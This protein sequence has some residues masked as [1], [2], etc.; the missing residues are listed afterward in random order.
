MK[1]EKKKT[2]YYAGL[3]AAACLMYALSA[4]LR[5]V[6]GIMLGTIAK[7]TGI[8]YATVSFVIAVGQLVF[9]IMQPLFGIVALKRSNAFV[10]VAGFLM[11]GVGLAAIPFC[12]SKWMLMLFLGVVLPAGTGAVSFGIILGAIIPKLGERRGAVAS[13]FINASSGLGSIILSPTL[14]QLFASVGFT[15]TMSFMGALCVIL[16]PIAIWASV[17]N[18]RDTQTAPSNPIAGGVGVLLKNAVCGRNYQYLMIGF[19]TCGFHMAIIETH[20]YSQIVSYQIEEAWAAI[21][22]SVYGVAVMAGALGSGFLC[23]KFKMKNVLGGLY[24][25][26]TF[27][28]LAFLLLPKTLPIVLGI[29]VLLGL[30]SAATVVPTAGLVSK[31]FGSQTLGTLFGFV[32]LCHQ[33]GSFFSAWLGGVCLS[34][35][36]NYV[37]IWCASAVLCLLAS[38]VSFRIT[39]SPQPVSK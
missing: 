8:D 6:Y 17:E 11:M 37:V 3:A 31:E 22:Y 25:S 13:G 5:S 9:G 30:T 36:G 23:S 1:E 32:F 4:G 28:V 26:R 27:I 39:E 12:A 15:V 7:E 19:F 2:V 14:Q 34:V 33:L 24:G 18:K 29:A 10:L 16:I 38:V 35:T 21:A 20:L